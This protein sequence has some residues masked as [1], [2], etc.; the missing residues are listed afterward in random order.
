MRVGELLE[1]SVMPVMGFC[2]A[3]QNALTDICLDVSARSLRP[4]SES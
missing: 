4:M 3:I 1:D 2:G